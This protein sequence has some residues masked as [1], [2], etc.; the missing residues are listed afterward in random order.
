MM[1]YFLLLLL[2]ATLPGAL[3]S[4]VVLLFASFYEVIE[5]DPPRWTTRVEESNLVLDMFNHWAFFW[6]EEAHP[7]PF[8]HDEAVE[9]A[10][11]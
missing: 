7:T 10:E 6:K 2:L 1:S 5:F 9:K 3:I 4:L 8:I 11:L